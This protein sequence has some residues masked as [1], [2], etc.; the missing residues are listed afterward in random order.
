[1]ERLG[2]LVSNQMTEHTAVSGCSHKPS[3]GSAAQPL[4]MR[5]V[6]G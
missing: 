5:E 6:V 3:V 1:M 4:F 2:K